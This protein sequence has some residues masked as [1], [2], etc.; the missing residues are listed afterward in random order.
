MPVEAM[1]VYALLTVPLLTCAVTG[2][3]RMMWVG[4]GLYAA[5]FLWTAW[6]LTQS[7]E[8]AASALFGCI[9]AIVLSVGLLTLVTGARRALGS[10]LA[11][12]RRPS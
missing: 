7:G 8:S 1:V 9:S 2:S 3:W 10:G 6:T 12:M 11:R 5:F 4:A